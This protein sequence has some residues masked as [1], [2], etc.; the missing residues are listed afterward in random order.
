MKSIEAPSS[1]ELGT[2]NLDP[3]L[4]LGGRPK[5]VLLWIAKSLAWIVVSIGALLGSLAIHLAADREAVCHEALGITNGIFRG[6]IEV[7]RCAELSLTSI[8]LRRVVIRHPANEPV[9]RAG[10]I[11]LEPDLPR[12]MGGTIA[13]RELRV[14]DPWLSLRRGEAGL[15]IAEAFQP[16]EPSPEPDTPSEP[17]AI[18]AG[19]VVIERG[20]IDDLPE[21][22]AIRRLDVDVRDVFFQGE[23]VEA[24]IESVRVD[25]RRGSDAIEIT[26][27]DGTVSTREGGRSHVVLAVRAGESSLSTDVRLV[28]DPETPELDA[29]TTFDVRPA[30]LRLASP[31][32]AAA[33]T[34]PVR[35]TVRTHGSLALLVVS[36]ELET[37]GGPIAI[38]ATGRD[39]DGEPHGDVVV[40]TAGLDLHRVLAAIDAETFLCGSL[41]VESEAP[42][43]EG[44]RAIHAVGRNWEY[45]RY[46]LPEVVANATLY[47]DRAELHDLALPHLTRPGGRLDLSGTYWFA[48]RARIDLDTH[49]PDLGR[50]ET[51]VAFVPGL[52]GALTAGVHGTF[53][54]GA[55]AVDGRVD[56]EAEGLRVLGANVGTLSVHGTASGPIRTP[57][58]DLLVA[59]RS[60]AL[61]AARLEDAE[62]R[63]SGGPSRYRAE[64][65]GRVALESGEEIE[66]VSVALGLDASVQRGVYVV[67]GEIGASGVWPQPIEVALDS[68]AIDPSREV[69][70]EQIG[71]RGPGV[72]LAASGAYRFGGPSEASV[73]IASLDL[74]ALTARLGADL[75]LEG[76]LEGTVEMRGTPAE[77]D[78]TI[79]LD[80]EGAKIRELTIDEL[81]VRGTLSTSGGLLDADI[82]VD[83]GEQGRLRS[84]ARASFP[85][86]R[87]IAEVLEHA[88]F[89]TTVVVED[90]ML[91]AFE[92]FLPED[93]PPIDGELG[94]E[95]TVRGTVDQPDVE[96]VLVANQ[97]L[98]PQV[99]PITG[100]LEASLDATRLVADL[101]LGYEDEP[102]ATADLELP[103]VLR[104]FVDDP[105]AMAL[106]DRD[107]RV[108]AELLRQRLDRLPRPL[109]VAIPLRTRA[110]IE[111]RGPIE[112]LEA[113]AVVSFALADRDLLPNRRCKE[114]T[115]MALDAD[116]SVRSGLV[117]VD[118]RGFVARE[119]VLNGEVRAE[120]PIHRWLREEMPAAPPPVQAELELKD[121]TLARLPG[122][123]SLASGTIAGS[124]S[125]SELFTAQ[126][127]FEAQLRASGLTAGRGE[128]ADAQIHVEAD[129][130]SG[131][132]AVTMQSD[133]RRTVD[134]EGRAPIVWNA[135][136]PVPALADG[137]WR[138]RAAFDRAPFGPLAALVPIVAQPR[139]TL[140]GRIEASGR[141]NDFDASG[142][143]ALEHVYFVLERPLLRVDDLNGRLALADRGLS[144]RN[145]TFRDLGGT[146][147]LDGTIGFTS[148]FMPSRVNLTLETD[149]FPVRNSGLIV[150]TV[151]GHY[152]VTGDLSARPASLGVN[153]TRLGV[154]LPAESARTLQPLDQHPDV[155]YENQPGFLEGPEPRRDGEEAGEAE[156]RAA[157]RPSGEETDVTESTAGDEE[158]GEEAAPP[159][160]NPFLPLR[161]A[162]DATDPFWVRREDFAMQV[163]AELAITLDAAGVRI[164]GPI[165]IRRGYI[166]LLTKTFELEPSEIRFA[167]GRTL[168]PIL[169]VTARYELDSQ[170]T[171]TVHIT[172]RL[173]EPELAFSTTVPGVE[174]ERE[175]LE[176]LVRGNATSTGASPEDQVVS[177]LGGLTA[178]LLSGLARRE[179][180]DLLPILSIES[181]GTGGG[182]IRAGI[183]AD[184]LIPE[185]LEDI[186]TGAYFEGFVG[187]SAD[188]TGTQSATG[189][190]ELDLYFPYDLTLSGGYEPP[191]NWSWDLIWE[192]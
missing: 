168:D 106:L 36:A 181:E 153:V 40:S 11:V 63:V 2:V 136:Q 74:E 178:G 30:L 127:A 146:G 6:R 130:S 87:P 102:I 140:D 190:F 177:A 70:V 139:G 54:T 116:L 104:D 137:S 169:D 65:R 133:G 67:D 23:V 5:Q 173:G 129:S 26:R 81:A 185:F 159:S 161:V 174:T 179:Y 121:V 4:L 148:R 160:D 155:I 60:T 167:G 187:T 138:A 31:E 9:V 10:S 163:T 29:T 171:I 77:P 72:S 68:V 62:I 52:R 182:R 1:P 103:F 27:L 96:L 134:I 25:A 123:C 152:R 71:V 88:S 48:G 108:R 128:G 22:L 42:D 75:Q 85:P 35:G 95:M 78:L 41:T 162:V 53:D 151:D 47:E 82:E 189:G 8:E 33:I 28:Y 49:L 38:D 37:D 98:T 24:D 39:L 55:L 43:A 32:A 61:G 112:T 131:L 94:V 156:R 13:A 158:D 97:V 141:G 105:N 46:T 56:L 180:G 164:E 99:G 51:L 184:R 89:D 66:R 12:L 84:D 176:L 192:P 50:D 115:G 170:D 19:R 14:T 110:T 186:V 154:V 150:A 34:T 16:R 21:G 143:I 114:P 64:G 92:S 59:A 188:D 147:R 165:R 57:R 69:S 93:S 125:A 73:Q 124:I 18:V 20:R 166:D 157:G 3:R 183:D 80:V 172:G 86:R 142:S 132:V 144:I 100:R 175:I 17:P 120:A 135:E 83:L 113:D 58:V 91:D 90:L 7:G 107:F 145:L 109:Y 45:G 149:E 118:L 101:E 191:T 122:A 44:G 119:R 126:P 76:V 111:A 117:T 79:D 15:A